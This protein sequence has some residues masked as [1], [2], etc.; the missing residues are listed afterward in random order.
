MGA[1]NPDVLHVAHC[2]CVLQLAFFTDGKNYRICLQCLTKLG[3][4]LSNLH[5]THQIAVERRIVLQAYTQTH[6][7]EINTVILGKRILNRMLIDKRGD[8]STCG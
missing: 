6:P 3:F 5:R 4:D 2:A 1:Y 7:V 8:V